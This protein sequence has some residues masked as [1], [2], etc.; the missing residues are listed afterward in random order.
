MFVIRLANGEEIQGS[1]SDGLEINQETGVLTVS[2][3]DG[4]EEITTYYSPMAWLSVTH[5]KK[6]VGVRPSVISSAR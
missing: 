3:V 4:F 2:R 5:R 1:E 6:G